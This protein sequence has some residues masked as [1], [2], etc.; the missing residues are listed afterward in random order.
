MH[1]SVHLFLPGMWSH[2][3]PTCTTIRVLSP[4]SSSFVPDYTSRVISQGLGNLKADKGET[5]SFRDLVGVHDL[6]KA[7][8]SRL[9]SSSK[10]AKTLEQLILG[11]DLQVLID[12][13][14]SRVEQSHSLEQSWAR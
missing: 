10:N 14:C 1:N 6:W 5:P 13:M 3:P 9:Q 12:D 8:V 4:L 7:Y 11:A 2:V